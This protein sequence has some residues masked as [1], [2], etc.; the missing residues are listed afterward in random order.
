MQT[1]LKKSKHRKR[2]LRPVHLILT[3]YKQK[4]IFSAAR[5]LWVEFGFRKDTA[6]ILF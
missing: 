1:V 5:G 6:G 3:S 2:L 4:W